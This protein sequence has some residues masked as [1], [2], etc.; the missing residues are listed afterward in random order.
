MFA[1]AEKGEVFVQ[2]IDDEKPRS[3]TPKP[4]KDPAAPAPASSEED[5]ESFSVV[6]FSRDG[7]KL[8]LTSKKGWYVAS[9]ADGVARSRAHARRQERGQ[10]PEAD[11]G[12]LDAVR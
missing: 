6:S 2:R 9:V 7:S 8:L 11:R 1:Y 5:A 4:K 3:I 10:E 12:G